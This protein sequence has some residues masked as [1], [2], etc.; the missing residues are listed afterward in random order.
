[1]M[2][3]VA[4]LLLYLIVT[5]CLTVAQLPRPD[6]AGETLS[7]A[8][9]AVAAVAATVWRPRCSVILLTDGTTSS[10]TVFTELGGLGAPWGVTV[11][12]VAAEGKSPNMTEAL[13]SRLV[14]QARRVRQV[15]WCVTVVVVSD[16]SAFLAA[17]AEWIFKGRLLV[18]TNRLLAVTRRPLSH[19]RHLHT[20]FSMMNAMLLLLDDTSG[21]PRC[22]VYLFLPY[23]PPGA[24]GVKVATWT[25]ER[26][27]QLTS[28]LQLF[29]DKF[30]R[31][32][33]RPQ[34]VVAAEEFQPHVLVKA[35]EAPGR[36]LSFAGPM[37]ELLH[38]LAN[39]LNFT[40]IF[41]RP[42]DG[43]WGA[44]QPDGTWTGMVGM[45]GRQEADLGL[46][47]FGISATRAEM[48][49]FTRPIL[50]DYARIMAGRGRPEIDPWGFFLPLAPLVWVSILMA[51][52]VVFF[53]N[54]LL[55]ICSPPH[56]ARNGLW[57]LNTIYDYLCVLLHQDVQQPLVWWWER[58]VLGGWLLMTLVLTQS[59]SGTL[60]SLLAVRYIPQP[61]QTLRDLLNEHSITMIWEANTAYVQ[62]LK[63]AESG[64]FREVMDTEKAGRIM[65][66][67][68]T[69]YTYMRDELVRLG[70]HVFLGEDLSGKVLMAQDFSNTGRCDFYASK[71]IFLPFM[72][73]MIGQ[74]NSPLLLSLNE[75]IRSVTGAGLYG[76]WM[77]S[78]IPNSTSCVNAPTTITI[79]TSLSLTNLWGM[80]VLLAGGHLLALVVL[81]LEL[82]SVRNFY[83]RDPV[84]LFI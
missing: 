59:Y 7:V 12:Q 33:H 34:L 81:G 32:V 47:P 52:L 25:H 65:Y 74:K 38:L 79:N 71:E 16:D 78:T 45:V 23:S 37:A 73:C 6:G 57:L 53:A 55:Y 68:S 44:K 72:F 48:V 77:S 42:P 18:W 49:D 17:S 11:F 13:L 15:S 75:R 39:T 63:S 60:M 80:F 69:E 30:T 1:M 26:G 83:N 3:G 84:K 40:Y 50:I 19:L 29:P 64:I 70:T 41:R 10:T 61:L 67:K 31:F 51:L 82:L 22:S 56:D 2:S 76:H 46:G 5:V 62:Y 9:A 36:S 8:G 14:A 27:L 35:T 20:S 21:Y 4:S 28:P 66:V 24:S 58:L 54:L 43:S